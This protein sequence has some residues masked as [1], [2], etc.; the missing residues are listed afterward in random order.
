MNKY[1]TY[2]ILNY[3]HSPLLEEKVNVGILFHFPNGD[4]V[5]KHPKIFKRVSGLY[6]DFAD[7]QLKAN[8]TALQDKVNILISK[9]IDL[10]GN[11]ELEN[12]ISEEILRTDATVLKFSE[13]KKTAL[14]SNNYKDIVQDFYNLYFLNYN[15]ENFIKEKHDEIYLANTFK[16]KLFNKNKNALNYLWKDVE[17]QSKDTP[18]ETTVKFEYKWKNG[19]D[20]LV[21][22][23]GLD[24]EDE[25]RIINK[26][27]LI[28]SQLDFISK[29]IKNKNYNV[30]LII[31]TPTSRDRKI[32][33]AYDNAL[34]RLNLVGVSKFI[35]KEE[36]VDNYIT[37]VAKE[38]K[39]PDHKQG[40]PFPHITNLRLPPDNQ[41][42]IK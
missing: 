11:G 41:N 24:L 5:F 2:S 34:Q 33:K 20:N 40:L 23:V 13:P 21:K 1:F 12:I 14:Y 25:H 22:T 7:W 4:I 17:V 9:K 10:F 42:L 32:R 19:V 36:E 29:E 30:D 15:D 28:Y 38:I 37:K 26:A 18:V 8:L 39:P 31:S 3:V 6:D 35:Y 16:A 27:I